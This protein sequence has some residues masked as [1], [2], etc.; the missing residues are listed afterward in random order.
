MKKVRTLGLLGALAALGTLAQG[1]GSCSEEKKAASPAAPSAAAPSPTASVP[2]AGPSPDQPKWHPKS[3]EFEKKKAEQPTAQ[4]T[5]GSL[6]ANFPTDVPIYPDAKPKSSM[7]VS[8]QG[9]VV[10][11]SGASISDVLSHYREE[12]PAQGWTVDSVKEAAGGSK[13]IVKAHKNTR[14]T[15]ISIGTSQGGAGTEIGIALMGS[16]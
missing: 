9:L 11:D 4:V 5:Q 2:K 13:A 6:P 15:T 7:M 3:E 1:C 16:S 10:L 14:S 8:G 12:L